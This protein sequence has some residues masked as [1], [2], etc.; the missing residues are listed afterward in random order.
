M[1]TTIKLQSS[2]GEIFD[3]PIEIAKRSLMVKTEVESLGKETFDSTIPLP[4]VKAETLKK[5][6]EFATHHKDDPMIS[7]DEDAPEMTEWD[8]EFFKEREIC[9]KTYG[10]NEDLFSHVS[11]SKLFTFVLIN[12]IVDDICCKAR[13]RPAALAALGPQMSA[14]FA[15]TFNFT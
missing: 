12:I 7:K 5:A 6:I 13:R 8:N 15:I 2:C 9:S 10:R 3:V 11:S 1:T 4:N 14:G